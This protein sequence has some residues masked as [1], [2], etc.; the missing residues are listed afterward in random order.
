MTYTAKVFNFVGDDVYTTD[1]YPK[2][3]EAQA[4]SE[5]YIRKHK[6]AEIE[7]WRWPLRGLCCGNFKRQKK[8]RDI[9]L[10][11]IPCSL[12]NAFSDTGWA[13]SGN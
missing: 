11:S 3:S 13:V 1:T 6:I 5:R 9:S 10:D 2:I 7:V 12:R 4:E 8:V